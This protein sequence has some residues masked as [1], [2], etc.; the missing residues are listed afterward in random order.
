MED[1]AK[2]L[3]VDDELGP[4]ESLNMVL[5]PFYN[6]CMADNGSKAIEIIGEKDIDLV[7]LDLKMPGLQGIDTLREI[8]NEKPDIGV[9]ILTGYGTLRSAVDGIRYGASDYLMKPFNVVEIIAVTKKILEKRRLYNKFKLFLS[10]FGSKDGIGLF[11]TTGQINRSYSFLD[12]MKGA[13]DGPFEAKG[14][15]STHNYIEFIKVLAY[16]LENKDPHTDGHS[17]RVNYFSNLIAQEIPLGMDDRYYLQIGTYLHDIGKIGIDNKIILKDGKFNEQELEIARRHPEIGV[18]LVKSI[19]ISHQIISII[20]HHHEFFDGTGHP[21]GLKSEE[22]P[23][24]ARIVSVADSFDAMITDRPYRKALSMNDAI[25]EL[26]RCA[27]TQ[28]DPLLVELFVDVI[29]EKRE[30]ILKLIQQ[31]KLVAEVG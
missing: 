24:L 17:R 26:R 21:D 1:R 22:I 8:K 14:E 3:I 9:I 5:K 13:L 29:N 7:I 4:R 11:G 12:M 10:E 15:S 30:C 20:R 27:G 23:L 16:T 25:S 2:I 28:F 18:E 31:P 19:G 6:I